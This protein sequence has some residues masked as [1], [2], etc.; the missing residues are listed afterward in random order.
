MHN[1]TSHTYEQQ[2]AD[3]VYSRISDFFEQS[4]FLVEQLRRRNQ[5]DK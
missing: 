5:D 2:K 4:R 1:I 3:A